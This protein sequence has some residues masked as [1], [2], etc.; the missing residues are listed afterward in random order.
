[1]SNHELVIVQEAFKACQL[2]N[3]PLLYRAANGIPYSLLKYAMT[4]DGTI[5]CFC[6]L[7]LLQKVEMP[8]TPNSKPT[9]M[10]LRSLMVIYVVATCRLI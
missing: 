1:M 3:A 7:Y 5:R 9:H 8:I 6:C 10:R 4:V 2:V